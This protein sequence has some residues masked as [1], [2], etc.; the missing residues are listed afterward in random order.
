MRIVGIDISTKNI[1][2]VLLDSN[3]FQVIEFSS[4]QKSWDLRLQELQSQFWEFVE[5][6]IDKENDFLFIEEIPFVQNRQGL[7]RLVHA[8]AMCR[9]A[10]NHFGVSCT[11]VNVKTW[12]QRVVGTGNASKKDIADKAIDLYGERINSLSQDCL[13]AL[14]IA[15]YGLVTKRYTEWSEQEGSLKEH[16]GGILR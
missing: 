13:D 2:C 5:T 6:T 11:Y 7:I 4:K 1:A 16:F 15:T 12:K 3:R 8:L 14:L 10:A 9:V